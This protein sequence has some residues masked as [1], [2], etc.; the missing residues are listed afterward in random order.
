M[1][2]QTSDRKQWTSDGLY[3]EYSKAA[4]PIAEG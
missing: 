1:S 2:T 3:Y 4:N